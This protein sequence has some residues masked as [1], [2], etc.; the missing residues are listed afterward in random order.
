[1]APSSFS[2]EEAVEKS[3]SAS[4][5]MITIIWGCER[6]ILVDAMT[7]GETVNSDTSIRMLRELVCPR[8]NPTEV[9]L[10]RDSAKF[11]TSFKT[12]EAI[13]EFCW[14]VLPHPPYRPN[15]APSD[16]HLFVALRYVIHDMKFETDDDVIS[17]VRT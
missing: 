4:K 5:T 3:P 7:G 17:S 6:V 15:L 11:H 1:M 12:R 2:L 13:T 9:L 16:F 10:Q 8:K 14:I